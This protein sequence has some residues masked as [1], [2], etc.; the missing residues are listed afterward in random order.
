M[1]HLVFDRQPV[2]CQPVYPTLYSYITHTNIL[3][4]IVSYNMSTVI[5]FLVERLAYFLAV[6]M[7]FL[8]MLYSDKKINMSFSVVDAL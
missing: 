1:Q 3:Y 6:S 5:T 2:C 7:A 8:V 4:R